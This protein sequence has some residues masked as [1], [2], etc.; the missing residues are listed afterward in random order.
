MSALEKI[1]RDLREEL[2][3]AK[4]ECDKDEIGR[5][6]KELDEIRKMRVELV[7]K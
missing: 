3:D 6:K 7:T 5:L 1:Y 4:A 2:K